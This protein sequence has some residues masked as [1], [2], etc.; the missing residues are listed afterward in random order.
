MVVPALGAILITAAAGCGG[1]PPPTR[2][3][4]E[5]VA[6]VRSAEAVGAQEEPQAAYHLE[7]AREQVR[8]AEQLIDRGRTQEAGGA[9]MRA[10]AD[11]DLALALSHEADTREQAA[12]VR[13]QVESLQREHQ[14]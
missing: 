12:T 13:E 14:P 4:A 8:S 3:Q 7:L 1:A 11:A 10:K 5:A 6:A 2:A 9:L